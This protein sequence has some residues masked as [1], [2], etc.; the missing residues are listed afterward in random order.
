[1]RRV[2]KVSA[3]LSALVFVLV[4]GV[5]QG[6]LGEARRGDAPPPN[7]LLSQTSHQSKVH[8]V[9]SIL[10]PVS[11]SSRLE[12]IAFIRS[13]LVVTEWLGQGSNV[14]LEPKQ[15]PSKY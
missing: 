14:T 8:S 4:T 13:L 5:P 6:E 10:P 15:T 7:S 2:S 12:A 1:M 3:V 11:N 9:R